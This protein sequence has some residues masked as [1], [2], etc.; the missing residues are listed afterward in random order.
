MSTQARGAVGTKVHAVNGTHGGAPP[1]T[2]MRG[3][4]N[5]SS[6]LGEKPRR[7]ASA[8]PRAA[9]PIQHFFGC[10]FRDTVPLYKRPP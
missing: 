5:A 1:A 9:A 7:G 10:M 4:G 2:P 6:V 8:V 3:V